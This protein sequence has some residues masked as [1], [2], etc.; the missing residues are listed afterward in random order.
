[1]A[2]KKGARRTVALVCEETGH[3]TYTTTKNFTNTGDALQL[4]KYNPLVKHH[5]LYKESKKKLH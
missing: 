4:K 2:K 5:T 3:R 1:M